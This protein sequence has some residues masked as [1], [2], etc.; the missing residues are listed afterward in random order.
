[1]ATKKENLGIYEFLGADILT[2]DAEVMDDTLEPAARTNL[3]VTLKN[4]R[5]D[6]ALPQPPGP[7][8]VTVHAIG[9][10]G[11]PTP[12]ILGSPA[13]IQELSTGESET[14]SFIV[15]YP[16]TATAPANYTLHIHVSPL[17]VPAVWFSEFEVV[18]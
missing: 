13:T 9:L 12:T 15:D 2:A 18:P 17:F 14:C 16:A 1:M 6:F 10:G 7:I 11:T 3:N 4:L 5:H 8:T